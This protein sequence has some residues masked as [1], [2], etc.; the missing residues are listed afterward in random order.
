MLRVTPETTVDTLF[1]RAESSGPREVGPATAAIAIL[2]DPDRRLSAE[3]AWMP[4]VRP[5][6]V[7]QVL[8]AI[9]TDPML[10]PPVHGLPP[11]ARANALAAALVSARPHLDR[12]PVHAR[13][14]L[15]GAAAA[16]VDARE[17]WDHVN[18]ARGHA[19]L[20]GVERLSSVV[21]ALEGRSA[22]FMTAALD[23][24]APRGGPAFT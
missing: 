1:R 23:V 19:G 14:R 11:L 13:V 2:R 5:G 7:L 10:D 8:N 16:S 21:A 20:P 15:L 22:W 24:L 18:E 6:R 17:V 4:H 12:E 3:V 9:E